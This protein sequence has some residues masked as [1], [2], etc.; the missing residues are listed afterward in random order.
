MNGLSSYYCKFAETGI[1][2]DKT[3]ETKCRRSRYCIWRTTAANQYGNFIDNINEMT[4]RD[5]V[6][7]NNGHYTSASCQRRW[8]WPSCR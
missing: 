8:N 3:S 2:V 6:A 4:D 5:R 7:C 1:N